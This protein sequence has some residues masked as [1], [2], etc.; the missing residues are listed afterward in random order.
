MAGG[1]SEISNLSDGDDVNSTISCFESMGAEIERIGRSAKVKGKGFKNFTKPISPLNAANSGTTARLFCGLLVAQDFKSEMIGDDSLSMRPMGRVIQPLRL[2]GANIVS[3][4][5]ETLPIAIS[6]IDKLQPIDYDLPV[7]SAQVKSAILIAGLHCNG[8]TTLTDKYSTRDHTERMLNL[9]ILHNGNNRVISS[10]KENYPTPNSYFIPSDISTASF[11]I[12]L[13]LLSKKSELKIKDISLNETR[14]GIIKVLRKMGGE[15]KIQNQKESNREKY[16]D[17]IVKSSKL[18]NITIEEDLV[19]IIID[20]IPILSVAGLF[21]EGIFQIQNASELRKKESDRIKSLC[22]N[23]RTLGLNI[24]E[25][26]D[27]F[28]INGKIRNHSPV[29][30]SFGDHRIAMAFSILS[31]LLKDGGKINNYECVNISNP[32]FISQLKTIIT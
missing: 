21:A 11:F 26:P 16:G 30:E 4:S 8:I 12:V 6:P 29:F 5:N 22:Y 24:D 19:P 9:K 25:A 28:A 27:G 20:E 7:A 13:T 14:I 10:S 3:T 15:I 17:I 23:Y 18:K 2:M 1:V 31:M 32:N